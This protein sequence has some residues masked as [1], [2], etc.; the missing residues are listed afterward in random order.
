MISRRNAIVATAALLVGTAV[1]ETKAELRTYSVGNMTWY[2]TS[3]KEIADKVKLFFG[4]AQHPVPLVGSSEDP[5]QINSI[6]DQFLIGFLGAPRPVELL[7]SGQWLFSGSVPHMNA[8]VSFV[9]MSADQTRVEA[10]MMS[11]SLC[12]KSGVDFTDVKGDHH[13][14]RC[15]EDPG[16]AIFISRYEKR[17]EALINS[18]S[19]VA[20]NYRIAE[21]RS[22]VKLNIRDKKLIKA[23]TLVIIVP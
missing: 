16:W 18:L 1:S 3:G 14:I 15:E 17:D 11:Y 22:M 19:Q 9:V 13:V 6:T 2:A 10:A 5:S 4:A 8:Y 7:P 23:K 21:Q 20:L 12:P